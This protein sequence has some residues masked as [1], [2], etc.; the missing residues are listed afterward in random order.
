LSTA[1]LQRPAAGAVTFSDGTLDADWT[2]TPILLPPGNGFFSYVATELDGNPV[3]QV[4]TQA[5][6]SHGFHA[7]HAVLT[8]TRFAWDPATQG[9]VSAL[10]IGFDFKVANDAGVVPY[11]QVAPAAIQAGRIYVGAPIS[12]ASGHHWESAMWENLASPLNWIYQSPGSPVPIDLR[13]G[14][15]LALGLAFFARERPGAA[16]Y[17]GNLR[18][19]NFSATVTAASEAA[20]APAGFWA[21]C[22]GLGSRFFVRRRA[23]AVATQG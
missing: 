23:S 11:L 8:S 22:A 17:V 12:A 4:V 16:G 6:N 14:P 7:V 21:F 2:G 13:T 20:A 15:T 19:N 10:S 3:L 18:I 1:A 5:Q 9:A